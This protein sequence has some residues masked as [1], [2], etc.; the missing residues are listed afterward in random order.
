[1]ALLANFIAYQEGG[2]RP[3]FGSEEA[4]TDEEKLQSRLRCLGSYLALLRAIAPVAPELAVHPNGSHVL[5]TLLD[6]IPAVAEFELQHRKAE[7]TQGHTHTDPN[8]RS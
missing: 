8:N 1:M 3:A 4:N 6:S 5:Q 2:R 7:D